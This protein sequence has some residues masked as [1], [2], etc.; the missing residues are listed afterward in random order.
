M[1]IFALR[2]SMPRSNASFAAGS[3][4]DRAAPIIRR[5]SAGRP[6]RLGARQLGPDRIDDAVLQLLGQIGVHRQADHLGGETIRYREPVAGGR[7]M[8]VGG[9]T[10]QRLWV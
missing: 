10:V 4:W 3:S 1:P 5:I 9:L 7:I 6:H 8:L 2:V